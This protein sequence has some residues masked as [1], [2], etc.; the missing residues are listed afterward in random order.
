M[1]G[2]INSM[3]DIFPQGCIDQVITLYTLMSYNFVN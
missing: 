3:E 1:D 2:L